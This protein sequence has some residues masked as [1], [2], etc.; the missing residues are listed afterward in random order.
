MNS[1]HVAPKCDGVRV[2]LYITVEENSLE[3]CIWLVSA[4]SGPEPLLFRLISA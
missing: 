4:R 3:Q 2:M 1:F